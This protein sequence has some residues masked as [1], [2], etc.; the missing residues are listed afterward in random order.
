MSRLLY[1]IEGID[2]QRFC[3][4]TGWNLHFSYFRIVAFYC[5]DGSKVKDMCW[6]RHY[7]YAVLNWI[8]QK[9]S[10]TLMAFMFKS[11][12]EEKIPIMYS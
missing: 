9:L 6:I 8:R 10:D 11:F 2:G 5:C 1:E 3:D 4:G 12:L 7:N